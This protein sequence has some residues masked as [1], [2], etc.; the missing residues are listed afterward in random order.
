MCNIFFFSWISINSQLELELNCSKICGHQFDHCSTIHT[1]TLHSYS[2]LQSLWSSD[3]QSI[4]YL[5]NERVMCT[6]HLLSE[7]SCFNTNSIIGTCEFDGDCLCHLKS[8]LWYQIGACVPYSSD[9]SRILRPRFNSVV[10]CFQRRFDK[11]S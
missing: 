9:K 5:L 7:I 2:R 1:T 11:R 8:I 10:Y 3:M 4:T 6:W